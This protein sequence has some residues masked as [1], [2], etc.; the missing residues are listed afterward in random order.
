MYNINK[1]SQ[2]PKKKKNFDKR[3]WIKNKNKKIPK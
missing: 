1:T 3:N 2:S